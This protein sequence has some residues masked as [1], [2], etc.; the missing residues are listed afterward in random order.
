VRIRVRAVA[1]AETRF[2][3]FHHVVPRAAGGR[4]TADNIQLRC[5]A[6]NGHGSI[7]SSARKRWVKEHDDACRHPFWNG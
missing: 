2:L 4:A 3:E 1:A 5:R 7:C 6:H